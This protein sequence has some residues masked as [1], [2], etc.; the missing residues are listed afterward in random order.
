MI[1]NREKV[2]YIGKAKNLKLRLSDYLQ[3]ENLSEQIRVMLS[4]VIKVEISITKNEIEA[5]L[6]ESQLIN[7]NQLR[8]MVIIDHR[9]RCGM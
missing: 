9:W 8:L 7:Y 5:L 2:L 3:F 6:L 4:Q 1:G